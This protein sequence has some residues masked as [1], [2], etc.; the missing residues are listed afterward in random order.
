VAEP[1]DKLRG[2]ARLASEAATVDLHSGEKNTHASTPATAFDR[3]ADRFET[4]GELGRG[5]MGRVEDAFDRTLGRQVAIKH[6]LAQNAVDFARFEREARI[7]ARLEHPGIVPIHEA[8]RGPDGT[9]YYV[10]RRVDGQPLSELVADRKSLGERL[11]LIPNV[12]AACDAAGFAHAR[13]IVHRDIKPNNILV[14]PFGETLLIDWGLARELGDHEHGGASHGPSEP[15]LTRAGQ[16]AGT[17]GFMAPEQARGEAVDARADVF[18]LGATLFFVLSGQLPWGSTSATELVNI[19]GA[20][21]APDWKRVPEDVPPDLRAV[22]EKAMAQD[23]AQ[24]YADAVA[25]A[26]DLRR[27]TLGNLVAAYQY[28]PVAK[29]VRYARKHRAAVGVGLISVVVLA[30]VAVISVRRIVAERDDA[31][32]ARRL[33]EVRQREA[34]AMADELLVRHARELAETDPAGTVAALRR[35]RPDSDRWREAWAAAAMAHLRGIPYG[36]AATLATDVSDTSIAISPDNRHVFVAQRRQGELTIYDIITRTQR[37]VSDSLGP[38][39]NLVWLDARYIA[40][41]LADESA[42]GFI[43]TTTGKLTRRPG[44]V[45]A[46]HGSGG[47]GR[48]WVQYRDGSVLEYTHPDLPPTTVTSKVEHLDASPDLRNAVI[49]RGNVV[50][51]WDRGKAYP[52]PVKRPIWSAAVRDG[53]MV[54]ADDTEV[55]SWTVVDGKLATVGRWPRES[56]VMFRVINGRP[57]VLTH[58]G[59]FGFGAHALYDIESDLPDT[60]WDSVGG[61][62]MAMH[63]GRI[64]IH[65]IDGR[66]ELGKRPLS[67]RRL[68][69]SNDR[70]WVAAIASTGDL[71]VWD[72][73]QIRPRRIAIGKVEQPLYI[74]NNQIWLLHV[75]EGVRMLDLTTGRSKHLLAHSSLPDWTLVGPEGAYVAVATLTLGTTVIYD[76]TLGESFT[77]NGVAAVNEFD[78]GLMFVAD[79]GRLVRW[80]PGT[81]GVEEF[82]RAPA[83]ADTVA[84]SGNIAIVRLTETE[85]AHIDVA[86]QVTT[87]MSFARPVSGFAID[88]NRVVWVVSGGKA[89]RW[90]VGKQPV[91]VETPG[92]VDDVMP[93]KG[94]LLLHC[95]TSI[96]MIKGDQRRVVALTSARVRYAGGEDLLVFETAQSEIGLLDVD[97]GSSVL[98]PYKKPLGA[99]VAANSEHVAYRDLVTREDKVH[100]NVWSIRVPRDSIALRAW[101]LSVTNAKSLANTDTVAYP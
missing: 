77:I 94:Y 29:L 85:I 66:Y 71:L 32:T 83:R 80:R 76:A 27:F 3:P 91:E 93:A 55:H 17:P 22:L 43:D 88:A 14:G 12:L 72:L 41:R 9:P 59:V 68:D 8:G 45:F 78:D 47:N 50:E 64:V 28:G 23:P 31:T 70:R 52:V 19:A 101:L 4:V 65:D 51:L 26:A 98:L 40:G 48:I 53:V 5:G 1:D 57:A 61:H 39:G 84:G 90:E 44:D 38:I 97:S 13:K 86:T 92:L 37:R 7:T 87:R 24:R 79:D 89:F 74:H 16:I 42:L 99:H 60:T 18:A 36:F 58:Q 63:D 21:R 15:S 75:T 2:R 73:A 33:A 35:L 25:L 10:M 20:G 11:Q 67:L 56:R 81:R 46:I 95:A 54:A 62:V 69:Y 6:M 96:V 82:A 100:V 49:R 34:T 30:A